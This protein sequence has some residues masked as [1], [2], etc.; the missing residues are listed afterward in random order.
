MNNASLGVVNLRFA[1]AAMHDDKDHGGNKSWIAWII[2]AVLLLIIFGIVLYL[3]PWSKKVK[4]TPNV[5][6]L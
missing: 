4:S 3:H 2:A 5:E 6:K 1:H